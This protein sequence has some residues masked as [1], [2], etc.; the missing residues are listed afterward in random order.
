VCFYPWADKQL[1]YNSRE[2]RQL[3]AKFLP[4]FPLFAARQVSLRPDG[5][6]TRYS[7][8]ARGEKPRGQKHPDVCK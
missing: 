5:E 3:Q 7:A 2:K 6:T 1:L 8:A 4:F